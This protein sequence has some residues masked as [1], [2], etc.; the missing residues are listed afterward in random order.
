[1]LSTMELVSFSSASDSSPDLPFTP[2][3]SPSTSASGTSVAET[4]AGSGSDAPGNQRPREDAVRHLASKVM[5]SRPRELPES[6]FGFWKM[7][8]KKDLKAETAVA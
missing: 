2:L 3:L 7:N 8:Y 5:C 1:M 4:A 6:E